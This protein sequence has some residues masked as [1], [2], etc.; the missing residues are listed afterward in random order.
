MTILCEVNG[1]RMYDKCTNVSGRVQPQSRFR[2]HVAFALPS[3]VLLPSALTQ[4]D[5]YDDHD[6]NDHGRRRARQGQ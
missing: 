3:L 6:R 2:S 5:H 4:D 1:C